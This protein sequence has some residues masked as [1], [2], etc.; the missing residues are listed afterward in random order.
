MAASAMQLKANR[1]NAQ[2][3]TGP[4]SEAGLKTSSQNAATHHLTGGTAFIEG[5]EDREEYETHCKKQFR[6]YKPLAEHEI[7]LVQEMADAIWRLKRARKME[8][9]LL[10]ASLNPFLE[11]DE[12]ISV[13][14]LRITKYI[15]AIERTYYKAYK[16][17]KAINEERNRM[18]S[19]P[20]YKLHIS[21][22]S[23]P[24]DVA[25]EILR[26]AAQPAPVRNEPNPHGMADLDFMMNEFMKSTK[27]T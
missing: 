6:Q 1:A 22:A 18:T 20:P 5:R 15:A 13:R 4:R 12:K 2:K 17:I 3:S 8:T 27:R 21:Y 16:E 10:E 7:F 14:L 11:D 9:E 24:L 23:E 25:E 26:N 19:A